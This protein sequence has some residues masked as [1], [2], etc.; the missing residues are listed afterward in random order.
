MNATTAANAAPAS[1]QIA[2]DV[3]IDAPV[4]QLDAP[5][6]LLALV[7]AIYLIR[8]PEQKY[9]LTALIDV[10]Q[11]QYDALDS[12]MAALYA[13][14]FIETCAGWAVPY[15]G[16]LVGIR[17]RDAAGAA[18][19]MPRAA[20]ANAVTYRMWAGTSAALARA[21]GA[22]TGWPAAALEDVSNA[23]AAVSL[24]HRQSHQAGMANIADL[25]AMAQVA[26][27]FN[28]YPRTVSV[29]A[30]QA[31]A[32]QTLATMPLPPALGTLSLAFWRLAAMPMEWVETLP[33]GQDLYALHPAGVPMP[34]FQVPATPPDAVSALT[35]SEV[36]SQVTPD[37]LRAAIAGLPA[38]ALPLQLGIRSCVSEEETTEIIPPSCLRVARLNEPADP[39]PNL[40]YVDPELGRVQLGAQYTAGRDG[41]F[42]VVATYAYGSAADLGGGPY[43]RGNAFILDLAQLSD[44]NVMRVMVDPAGVD[45]GA[46]ATLELAIVHCSASAQVDGDRTILILINDNNRHVLPPGYRADV[47][48]DTI[49]VVAMPGKRPCISGSATF[50]NHT[51]AGRST[52]LMDGLLWNGELMLEGLIDFTAIDC[53]IGQP[54]VGRDGFETGIRTMPAPSRPTAEQPTPEITVRL[55]NSIVG[56]CDLSKGLPVVL[57]AADSILDAG[58]GQAIVGT[59]PPSVDNC[60]LRLQLDAVTLFGDVIASVLLDCVDTLVTGTMV[61]AGRP[62]ERAPAYCVIGKLP[63]HAPLGFD[64]RSRRY[65]MPGYG[66]LGAGNP[67]QILTAGTN[68]QSPGAFHGLSDRQRERNLEPILA[69]LTVLGDRIR[70]AFTG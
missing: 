53:T 45:Q 9:P 12:N 68:E 6:S 33:L 62:L 8:D 46:F 41:P 13:D 26:G 21:C 5:Q 48:A 38:G 16:E 20:V 7:P 67:V 49:V 29:R 23:F 31:S 18:V 25:S 69:E 51:A 59:T 11:S 65:G 10:L 4:V 37:L 61:I 44:G 39:A 50:F 57:I 19:A 2:D 3:L 70:M 24:R 22:A 34:L 43:A 55:G 60:G 58:G 66:L 28:P 64:W 52:L 56:P 47:R 14:W 35:P 30:A 40:V 27:P 54:V 63:G 17:S 42:A 1:P 15:L 36:P 32:R